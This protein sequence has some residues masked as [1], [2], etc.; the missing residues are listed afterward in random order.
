[1]STLPRVAFTREAAEMWRVIPTTAGAYEVSNQ[2]RVRSYYRQGSP[3]LH[4]TP[5]LLTLTLGSDGRLVVGFAGRVRRVHQLVMEAFVGPRP[6]GQLIRHLD[7]D[8]TNNTLANLA[9][10]TN[11][12]NQLDRVR[13]GRHHHSERTHCGKGHPFSGENL[14]FNTRGARRCRACAAARNRAARVRRAAARLAE[15]AA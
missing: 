14:A 8:C 9:Y 10:G 1:M 4:A 13:H 12:E 2:G 3:R 7:G 11:S 6:E 5:V 15:V